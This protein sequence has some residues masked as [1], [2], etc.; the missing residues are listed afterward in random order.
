MCSNFTAEEGWKHNPNR[1]LFQKHVK[2][3][4]EKFDQAK[5]RQT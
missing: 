1:L 4:V 3:E 2:E 5:N